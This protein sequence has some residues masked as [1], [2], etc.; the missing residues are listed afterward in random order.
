MERGPAR[1]ARTFGIA[2]AILFVAALAKGLLWSVSLPPLTGPDEIMHVERIQDLAF[3]D[4]FAP[5]PRAKLSANVQALKQGTIL[6][7]DPWQTSARFYVERALPGQVG[8]TEQRADSLPPTPSEVDVQNYGPFTYLPYAI[9]V[10]A[11]GCCAITVQVAVER[12][13]SAL[14]GALAALAAVWAAREAGLDRALALAAAIVVALQPMWSQQTAVVTADAV[15]L[16]WATVILALLCRFARLRRP[17]AAVVMLAAIMVGALSK[18]EL[19]F[20]VPLVYVALIPVF[21]T[22]TPFWVR[23][24]ALLCGLLSIGIGYVATLRFLASH[25]SV[26]QLNADLGTFIARWTAGGGQ[27]VR[28]QVDFLWASFGTG[29][30]GLP[31]PWVAILRVVALVA[32]ALA[33][34][35]LWRGGP[36]GRFP[37]LAAALM[38]LLVVVTSVAFDYAAWTVTPGVGVNLSRYLLPGVAPVTVLAL[39]GARAA[40]GRAGAAVVVAPVVAGAMLV[41]AAALQ[42]L[43]AHFY[44]S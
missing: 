16:L 34:V 23:F 19:V 1:G 42:A 24:A 12:A 41:N 2:V 43:W 21:F 7:T 37:L 22:K 14:L 36:A 9:A 18:P 32:V 29:E 30:F 26:T 44:V 8:A 17:G 3:G 33:V 38:A 40:L 20:A 4:R 27:Y 13:V 5:G 15:E 28:S 11:A 39:A 35:A 6:T 31:D 25:A 10:R